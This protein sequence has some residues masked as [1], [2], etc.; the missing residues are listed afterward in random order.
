MT[1][2]EVK[3]LFKR[4]KSNYSTFV[5]D[6]YK[7]TEWCKELKD[8]DET[9]VHKK[10][11]EH[12]R[13]SEYGNSEPK[14]YFLTKYLKTT[15]E[16]NKIEK[17]LM[18][19]S[20]CKEFIPEEQYDK[21]YERCLDVEYIIKKRKELFDNDTSE[22]LKNAYLNMDQITFDNKYL[23]FLDKIYNYVSDEEKQRIEFII[24]PPSVDK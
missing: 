24:N 23:E 21:H 18:Q 3:N 6:E 15:S 5:A 20:I 10:L 11:E 4:I 17:Y 12:M 22:E 8:Y 1:R 19:C 9:D 7:L 16:K 2:D 14:L 13:S